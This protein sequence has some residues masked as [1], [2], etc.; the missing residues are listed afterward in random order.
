MINKILHF[1]FFFCLWNSVCIFTSQFGLATF[2]VFNRLM[3]PI[4]TILDSMA[5]ESSTFR[6]LLGATVTAS[7]VVWPSWK[8]RARTFFPLAFDFQK[9]RSLR[10]K[11]S[12]LRRKWNKFGEKIMTQKGRFL[13]HSPTSTHTSKESLCQGV[14]GNLGGSRKWTD[15]SLQSVSPWERKPP[16]SLSL[17]FKGG[18]QLKFNLVFRV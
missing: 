5:L 6:E 12:C 7:M 13:W 17:R 3:W 9:F 11:K 10:E 2:Q 14:G 4:A 16:A 18:G 1:F 15:T 8:K